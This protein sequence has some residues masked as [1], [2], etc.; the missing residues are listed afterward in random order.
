M[1]NEPLRRLPLLSPAVRYPEPVNP[2]RLCVCELT[3]ALVLPQP[4]ISHH[5][6]TLR[7]TELA[8]DR[9]AGLWMLTSFML[10]DSE[11]VNRLANGCLIRTSP[12][13]NDI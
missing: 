1:A 13:F 8:S 9:K 6:G 2:K 7:K 12:V 4:K 5:L 3:H 10:V 11:V